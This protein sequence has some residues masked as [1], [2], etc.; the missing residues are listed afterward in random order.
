MKYLIAL[1]GSQQHYDAMAG[2]SDALPNWSPAEIQAML[3]HMHTL[4]EELQKNGELVDA[5]GLTDP[6]DAR[7]VQL[8][9]GK[10]VVTDGP[11]AETKEVLAGYWVVECDSLDRATE[12]A[13]RA[14]RCPVPEGF[15]TGA[16]VDIRP[17][18]EAPDPEAS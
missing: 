7:R 11:Y 1:A 12:I 17:I 4:N 5:Q 18:G 15:P 10:L 9:G 16:P 13:E 3:D 14:A 6:K 2:K 8:E